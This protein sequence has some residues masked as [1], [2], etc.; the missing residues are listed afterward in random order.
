[1]RIGVCTSFED[2]HL[3]PQDLDFI[4]E[5]IQRFLVPAEPESAFVPHRDAAARCG[6]PLPAANSYLPASIPIGRS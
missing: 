3:L 4:E 2:A 5:N 6:F 1:M